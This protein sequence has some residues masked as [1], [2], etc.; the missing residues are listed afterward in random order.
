MV[1]GPAEQVNIILNPLEGEALVEEGRV[2]VAVRKYLGTVEP[3]KGAETVVEGNEDEVLVK[4][5]SGLGQDAR[6]FETGGAGAV[7]GAED[8]AAAVDLLH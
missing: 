1:L 6:G 3:A 2:S 4:R 8:A 5:R 7:F